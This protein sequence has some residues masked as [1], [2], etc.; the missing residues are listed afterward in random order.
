MHS[1]VIALNWQSFLP[2]FQ[3]LNPPV[4][5]LM[6]VH[7]DTG[8]VSTP[9]IPPLWLHIKHLHIRAMDRE[10][11]NRFIAQMSHHSSGTG[12]HGERQFLE[13]PAG[14]FF[15]L[16]SPSGYRKSQAV[17]SCQSVSDSEQC[18]AKYNLAALSGQW[19]SYRSDM[20]ILS[21]INALPS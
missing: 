12:T 21:F 15:I 18:K 11:H 14:Q 7:N 17:R 13:E 9:S 10:C 20:S 19:N 3:Y 1:T 8:L 6:L 5:S 4:S 2:G 16:L